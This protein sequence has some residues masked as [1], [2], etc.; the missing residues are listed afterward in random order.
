MISLLA[1]LL[2]GRAGS[3]T[4]F[5]GAGAT[6]TYPVVSSV[7]AAY[8]KEGGPEIQFLANGSGAGLLDLEDGKAGFAVIDVPLTS[9]QGQRGLVSIPFLGEAVAV[10]CKIPALQK[11][12]RISGKVLAEIYLGKIRYWDDPA[13]RSLNR[14]A[15]LPHLLA[16]VVHETTPSAATGILTQYLSAASPEFTERVGSGLAVRWPVGL[17]ARYPGT[18][19]EPKAGAIWSEWAQ[20]ASTGSSAICAVQNARGSFVAPTDAG[21]EAEL[22]GGTG[23]D[24][25]PICGEAYFVARKSSPAWVVRFEVWLLG[26]K[27]REAIRQAGGARMPLAR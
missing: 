13:I 11:A 4:P 21:I 19:G 10:C 12:P 18:V 16:I 9:V 26:P 1:L 27:G 20:E 25:Y 23:T 17:G 8:R 3:S 24:R 5:I 7:L 2:V 15:K 6:S 14:G 22:A